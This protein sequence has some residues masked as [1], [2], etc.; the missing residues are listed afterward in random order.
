MGQQVA[1]KGPG[2]KKRGSSPGD[3]AEALLQELSQ[4][5]KDGLTVQAHKLFPAY[6]RGGRP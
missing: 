5:C 1:G 6:L 4:V 3:G 2:H